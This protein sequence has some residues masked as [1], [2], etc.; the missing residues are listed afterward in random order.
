M[1]KIGRSEKIFFPKLNEGIISAKI[2][3]GAFSAALHVDSVKII[4]AGLQVMIKQ[5][6]YIF[7][8]WSEVDVKSSNGKIQKR[9]GIKLKM[10]LGSKNFNIFVSLT[11]RK[12]MKF[13][14]LIGRRFL[15]N[16]NFIVDV[17][18]K[19]IHGRPKKI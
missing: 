16:N 1:K 19:N 2:D 11:N 6:T 7:H 15:H 18:K 5:N 12:R 14:L 8:R 13:P 17:K 9:Y 4:D 10:K 3:T